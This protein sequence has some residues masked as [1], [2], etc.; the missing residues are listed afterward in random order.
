MFKTLVYKY[1]LLVLLVSFVSANKAKNKEI[2]QNYIKSLASYEELVNLMLNITLDISNNKTLESIQKDISNTRVE[3]KKIEELISKSDGFHIGVVGREKVGKSSLINAW[4]GESLLPTGIGRT[5]YTTTEIKS[6]ETEKEQ[7]VS[8]EYFSSS[9][10]N[11]YKQEIFNKIKQE[12]IKQSINISLNETVEALKKIKESNTYLPSDIGQLL[13]EYIEIREND[14]QEAL[15]LDKWPESKP[16]TDSKQ[17]EGLLKTSVTQVEAR[18]VKR[19]KIFNKNVFL[20]EKMSSEDENLRVTI[21]DMPGFNSHVALHMKQLEEKAGLFDAI[22]FVRLFRDPDLVGQELEVLNILKKQDKFFKLKNK[23]FVALTEPEK[24]DSKDDFDKRLEMSVSKWLS[25]NIESNRIFPVSFRARFH[26]HDTDAQKLA[27]ETLN[28]WNVSDGII[29]LKKNVTE[30]I[31]NGYDSEI[32][33][34]INAQSNRVLSIKTNILNIGKSE[35]NFD[36]TTFDLDKT[37]KVDR[38]LR[39][40]RWWDKKWQDIKDEFS[41]FHREYVMHNQDSEEAASKYDPFVKYRKDYIKLIDH[42]MNTL[43]FSKESSQRDAHSSVRGDASVGAPGSSHLEMRKRAYNELYTKME[44]L[45]HTLEKDIWTSKEKIIN[46]IDERLFKIKKIRNLLVK[47]NEILYKNEIF[48]RVNTLLT[49]IIKPT[50]ILFINYPRNDGRLESIQR[51]RKLT[52][53]L[54]IFYQ[55]DI[56]DLKSKNV[57][58]NLDPIVSLNKTSNNTKIDFKFKPLIRGLPSYL[59]TGVFNSSVYTGL[60][61]NIE[62]LQFSP[63]TTSFDQAKKEIDQDLANLKDYL[64]NSVYY[65]SKVYFFKS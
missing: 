38:N 6:C 20:G 43:E 41:K 28:R 35:F 36:D 29:E 30:Y 16:Y 52:V 9:E 3:F 24:S 63:K 23:I 62:D 1:C 40:N 34:K 50:L 5:T 54:D 53:M 48:E 33:S 44:S 55:E 58:E 11:A 17:V 10:Y 32:T 46:W 64:I 14:K 42:I 25:H 51:F 12:L 31:T 47:N 22:I 37:I 59:A 19:A 2:I 65:A 8:I 15:Y 7:L 60:E 4:L 49:Y 18:T 26:P 21:H 56:I 45:S 57:D 39:I 61:F 13:N 27:K